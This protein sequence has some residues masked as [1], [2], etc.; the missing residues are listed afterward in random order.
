MPELTGCPSF[1]T[2]SPLS[3]RCTP[4]PAQI[5]EQPLSEPSHSTRAHVAFRFLE[6][7]CGSRDEPVN[8]HW[9]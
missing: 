2:C 6:V 4:S 1:G 9:L 8:L 7:P 3:P 5:G